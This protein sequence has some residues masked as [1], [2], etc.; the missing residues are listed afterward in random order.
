MISSI[1]K[2]L[3]IKHG[4]GLTVITGGRLDITKRLI[5][6]MQKSEKANI[7]VL[8]ENYDDL[9]EDFY[10]KYENDELNE[11]K[12][13]QVI[14]NRIQVFN[15]NLR[16]QDDK[17]EFISFLENNKL[18]VIINLRIFWILQLIKY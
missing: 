9:K 16:N 18:K 8:Y 5:E 15:C 11:E 6:K 7:I 14:S 1:K 4:N 17:D 2:L 13:R 12:N 10:K 3:K